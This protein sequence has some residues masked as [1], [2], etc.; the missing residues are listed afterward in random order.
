[1]VNSATIPAPPRVSPP[2]LPTV[3]EFQDVHLAEVRTYRELRGMSLQVREGDFVHV[4]ANR[5]GLAPGL[6][7]VALGLHAPKQ[8]KVAF[9]GQ[10][11]R[12]MEDHVR[13]KTRQ[14]IGRVFS[15]EAWISNLNVLENVILAKRYHQLLPKHVCIQQA[16]LLSQ[17]LG[18]QQTP[19]ERAN[20]LPLETLHI[21]QWVRA[22]LINPA[23]LL[24]ED[25]LLDAS[26]T[27][28]GRL[29]AHLATERKRGLAVLWLSYA[30]G[31]IAV[32]TDALRYELREERLVAVPSGGKSIVKDAQ[33]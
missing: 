12:G 27:S 5:H 20:L 29:L 19:R 24:L 14:Q 22:L 1:M 18:L 13:R 23:I 8:G 17:K 2:A 33:P 30:E 4:R 15:G 3:L 6:A 32:P 7:Y 25:P 26:S 28:A 10:D 11:W 9:R 16:D 31:E 21:A